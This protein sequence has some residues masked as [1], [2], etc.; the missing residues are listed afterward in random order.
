MGNAMSA[1]ADDWSAGYYNPAGSAFQTKPALGVGYLSANSV[2]KGIG[3]SDPKLD[4]TNG[5]ILGASIP[6]PFEEGSFFKNRFTFG[7]SG[8]LPTGMLLKMGV[9]APTEPNLILLQNSSRSSILI[10]NLGI[11]ITKGFAIGAGVQTFLDTKGELYAYI[12]PTGSVQ[13]RVGEELIVTY[14]PTAGMLFKPGE[15]WNVMN[16]WGFGFVYRHECFTKY[17]IPISAALGEIPFILEFNSISLYLPRQYVSAVSYEWKRW[18]L[19]ADVTYNQWSRFPDPHLIIEANVKIPILPIEFSN[20]IKHVPHFHDTVAPRIGM[21]VNAFRHPNFDLMVRG[22]YGY[23]QSPVP[24][25]RGYTNQLDTDRYIG[26]ASLGVK[27][28]G[29]N[30]YRFGAPM[31]FD[32]GAQ[33]QYLARRVS[34]KSDEISRDN[35]GY[36]KVGM[37]GWLFLFGVSF[38][39]YFDYE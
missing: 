15:H 18:R 9:A 36:P 10:P 7:F 23:E 28:Y 16:G 13:T 11:R 12:D 8:F 22:G 38:S 30:K 2:I 5:L 24:P 20:S 29:T 31:I 21:E 6:L 1:T 39:T 32:L 35:P 14:S 19:E 37:E 33:T 27:W 4:P 34:F 3:V 26:S 25:Q 17:K